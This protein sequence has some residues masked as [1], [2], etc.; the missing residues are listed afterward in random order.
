LSDVEGHLFDVVEGEVL[1]VEVKENPQRA[2]Q[3]AAAPL[4]QRAPSARPTVPAYTRVRTP[5]YT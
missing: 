2:L 4:D 3:S 5:R 1:R